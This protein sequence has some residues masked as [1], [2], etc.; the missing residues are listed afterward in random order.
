MKKT[1]FKK[2]IMREDFKQAHAKLIKEYTHP[3]QLGIMT[4]ESKSYVKAQTRHLMQ[5]LGG[6]DKW[7]MLNQGTMMEALIN[8]FIY[9]KPLKA[10]FGGADAEQYG[11]R[12]EIKSFTNNGHCTFAYD[13]TVEQF[14]ESL[15][16]ER[17]QMILAFDNFVYQINGEMFAD[18]LDLGIVLVQSTGT[19]TD[20]L[21]ELLCIRGTQK[22][23]RKL[24]PYLI[25]KGYI[26]LEQGGFYESLDNKEDGKH[27]IKMFKK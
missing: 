19:Q 17:Y 8:K 2:L 15:R 7:T 4:L 9:N 10:T 23:Y 26:N 5:N 27:K 16:N 12:Y 6:G 11:H 1:T 18:L 24:R 3:K 22:N 20:N 21:V 14:I 25:Y 13:G